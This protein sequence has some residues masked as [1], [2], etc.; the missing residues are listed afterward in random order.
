MCGFDGDGEML[1][2]T[3]FFTD[4]LLTVVTHSFIPCFSL[5]HSLLVILHSLS[6]HFFLTFFS[7]F[8]VFLSLTPFSSL[9]QSI[10]TFFSLL[11]LTPLSITHSSFNHSFL[12]PSLLT[13]LF[14]THS[15]LTFFSLSLC[16]FLLSLYSPHSSLTPYSC[17]LPHSSLLV[18]HFTS[19]H[20]SLT[21]SPIPATARISIE[22]QEEIDGSTDS[23]I[24]RKTG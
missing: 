20:F 7:F 6:S 17:L 11:L 10:L 23:F 3:H 9:T 22:R 21:H 19:L 24:D 16:H 8:S 5:T 12:T 14:L 13:H 4:L 18:P 2:F 15:F 1:V